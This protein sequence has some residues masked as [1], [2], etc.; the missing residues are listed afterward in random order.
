MKAYRT[1][2]VV[3]IFF[4]A[5]GL[6]LFLSSLLP[7]SILNSC[8]T[9]LRLAGV[10]VPGQ[11]FSLDVPKLRLFA[12]GVLAA[13]MACLLFE[14]HFD[15]LLDRMFRAAEARRKPLMPSSPFSAF[16][17][18]HL[19]WLLLCAVLILLHDGR[20]LACGYFKYDDFAFLSRVRCHSV[21]E[22]LLAVHGDQT[23][24]LYFLEVRLLR[25]LLGVSPFYWNIVSFLILFSMQYFAVLLLREIGV[26]TAG[27]LFFLIV[28]TG[29]TIWGRFSTGYYCLSIYLQVLTCSLL[30]IY[31]ALRWLTARKPVWAVVAVLGMATAPFIHLSGVYVPLAVVLFSLLTFAARQPDADIRTGLRTYSWLALSSLVVMLLFAGYNIYVFSRTDAFLA[32]AGAE[33]E[34]SP[35][36]VVLVFYRLLSR[37]VILSSI[38]PAGQWAVDR[39]FPYAPLV[40]SITGLGFMILFFWK[41]PR[42]DRLL[43]SGILI[44]ILGLAVMV[45]LGRYSR[46]LDELWLGKYCSPP[47]LWF[48]MLLAYV[49][50]S[51]WRRSH[52]FIRPVFVKATVLA[53]SVYLAMQYSAT[54]GGELSLCPPI[55]RG[56]YIRQAKERK[57][58]I[59]HLASVYGKLFDDLTA[60]TVNMP[61][62]DAPYI[63][64]KYPCLIVY[65]L[66]QYLDVITPKDRQFILYRNN[67]MQTLRAAEIQTVHSLRDTISPDVLRELLQ[68]RDLRDLYFGPVVLESI[69]TSASQLPHD[70]LSAPVTNNL[71][72]AKTLWQEERIL[73]FESDGVAELQIAKGTFDPEIDHLLHIGITPTCPV[74]SSEVRIELLFE[75]EL[76]IAYPQCTITLANSKSQ[77]VSVDLLQIYA[78]ALSKSITNL[79]L[80]FPARG[81]YRVSDLRLLPDPH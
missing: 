20:S 50:H 6:A 69:T 61:T 70:L 8:V 39:L 2:P 26:G 59:E 51:L 29:W 11:T 63:V 55:G 12:F 41:S 67:A 76:S 22:L 52:S 35:A 3:S 81:C 14:K 28:S 34:F 75:G 13:G 1:F 7:Y 79:R 21:R 18:M 46:N 66:S 77:H 71:S 47:F 32:M 80:R 56:A 17:K 62:L 60:T 36:N 64:A 54:Y 48:C 43:A 37:G 45:A 58:A 40:F 65:N 53:L 4:L 9:N 73:V 38:L 15:R 74:A 68:N 27:R 19:P 24:P 57:Q 78:Y 5:S 10:F 49:W 72:N 16:I 44:V 25:T 33:G 30:A 42:K 31:A 23:M